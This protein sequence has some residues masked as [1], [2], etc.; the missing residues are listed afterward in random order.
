MIAAVAQ[1]MPGE[2]VT[3][4]GRS[5]EVRR[6]GAGWAGATPL[7][8]LHE[9]LGSVEL[10]REFPG[11][12]SDATR[13]PAIVYSRAGYGWSDPVEAPRPLDFMDHEALVVLPKLL[14][15]FGIVAPWL[16]GHSDGASIGLI[17]AGSGHPVS[18]LVLI[19]PHVL[20]EDVTIAGIEEA[21]RRF[22]EGAL[23]ERM[24]RYHR[25]PVA[26][27]TSWRDVWL[28][29]RF[30]AWNIE[31]HLSAIR[32]PVLAVQGADDEF[33][34][35]LQIRAIERGIAGDVD[36]LILPGCGHSPHLAQPAAVVGAVAEFVMRRRA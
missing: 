4:D 19:A 15:R 16:V 24:L 10:W 27:F 33:G 28:S 14:A 2:N 35:A 1:D 20:V 29:P 3:V 32:G 5:L 7:V 36:T 30:R 18:G 12:L 8:F 22:E 13:R 17:H 26:T 25:D 34:T 6:L 31:G 11:M 23:A 9:G 21:S